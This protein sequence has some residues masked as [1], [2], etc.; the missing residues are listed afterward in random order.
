MHFISEPESIDSSWDGKRV[1]SEAWDDENKKLVKNESEVSKEQLI[2][3]FKCK[4]N[5]LFIN[6][7]K[8]I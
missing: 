6:S 8:H 3:L 4:M 1:E 5:V 2:I 7:A